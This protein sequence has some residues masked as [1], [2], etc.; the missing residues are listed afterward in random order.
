MTVHQ[1]DALWQA[2]AVVRRQ[3]VDLVASDRETPEEVRL[4]AQA[5][6]AAE[7]AK[8]LHLTGALDRMTLDTAEC[9]TLE[10]ADLVA[11]TGPMLPGQ[12]W[13]VLAR[14]ENGKTTLLMNLASRWINRGIGV[15]YFPTE[16]EPEAA[17][18]RFAALR[19][20]NAPVHVMAG[21]WDRIGGAQAER[22][23]R[24]EVEA[25]RSRPIYFDGAS[26]PT[27]ADVHRLLR[28]AEGMGLPVVLLD[29]FHRMAVTDGPNRTASLEQ[30]VRRIK[31]LAVET[32]RIV[33]MAAQVHRSNDPLQQFLPPPAD[34]GKG[35]GAIEEESD[36]MLGLYR[37]L[38]RGLEKRDLARF[39]EGDL[40]RDDI[41]RSH[42][43]G[44]KVLKHRRNSDLSGRSVF[45]HCERGILTNCWPDTTDRARGAA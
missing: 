44:I 25:L 22:E 18:L 32:G 4:T 11:A 35:T 40:S 8:A 37:P 34:G 19:S 24:A 9:P 23:V 12:L 1:N 5:M 41:T 3:V 43:M 20:G 15:A 33:L 16:E 38:K 28:V 31:T 21:E 45:L 26:A 27:L 36:V 14:P 30:T 6:A 13:T 2:P 39:H 42:L 7:D 17:T 29:H 10:Y